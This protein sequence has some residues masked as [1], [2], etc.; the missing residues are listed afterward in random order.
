[1]LTVCSGMASQSSYFSMLR[2]Y[3]GRSCLVESIISQLRV[4]TWREY[5]LYS[6]GGS[7]DKGL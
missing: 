3:G 5:A 1:M 6:F 2:F 7:H 4:V